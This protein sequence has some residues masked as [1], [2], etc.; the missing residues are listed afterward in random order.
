MLGLLFSLSLSLTVVDIFI[1]KQY[2]LAMFGLTGFIDMN[3]YL[4]L[5]ERSLPDPNT[6][7]PKIVEGFNYN[8]RNP[9]ESNLDNTSL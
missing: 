9:L 3:T 5:E 2:L 1:W 7:Y 6:I 4:P 8:I